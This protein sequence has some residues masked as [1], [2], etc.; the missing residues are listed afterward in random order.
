MTAFPIMYLHPQN[1]SVAFMTGQKDLPEM[2][3][4]G[5]QIQLPSEYETFIYLRRKIWNVRRI[6]RQ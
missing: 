1:F 4:L 3:R 2:P 5:M 6:P